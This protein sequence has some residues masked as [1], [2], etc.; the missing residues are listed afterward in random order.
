MVQYCNTLPQVIEQ[1]LILLNECPL[2]QKRFLLMW[3]IFRQREMQ[4]VAWKLLDRSICMHPEVLSLFCRKNSV[5]V[6]TYF[7]LVFRK[8]ST[9]PTDSGDRPTRPISRSK[10]HFS[11]TSLFFVELPKITV[12]RTTPS[13]FLNLWHHFFVALF[14]WRAMSDRNLAIHFC[15]KCNDSISSFST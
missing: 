6:P 5:F 15:A 1:S 11:S 8:S 3:R 2:A 4:L 12:T 14:F 13:P 7:F 10:A 9:P